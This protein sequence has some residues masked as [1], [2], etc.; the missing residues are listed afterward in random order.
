MAPFVDGHCDAVQ[1]DGL[2]VTGL[3][4]LHHPVGE[5]VEPGGRRSERIRLTV[6]FLR[7]WAD[8]PEVDANFPKVASDFLNAEH[9]WFGKHTAMDLGPEVSMSALWR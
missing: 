7:Y 4:S 6:E 2:A 3:C 9:A 1:D 5:V 8:E